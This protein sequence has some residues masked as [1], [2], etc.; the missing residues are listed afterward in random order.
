MAKGTG[1]SPG[2]GWSSLPLPRPA[3]QHLASLDALLKANAHPAVLRQTLQIAKIA[4]HDPCQLYDLASSRASRLGLR[5]P[6]FNQ[7]D[8]GVSVTA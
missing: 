5:P 8:P 6:A 4:G 2:S 1:N 7:V 3:V